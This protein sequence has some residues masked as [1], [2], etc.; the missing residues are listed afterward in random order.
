MAE[1]ALSKAEA[2]GVSAARVGDDVSVRLE[3][4]PTSG[5]RWELEHVDHQVLAPAGDEFIAEGAGR[6]AGGDRV[7]R[8]HVAKPGRTDVRLKRWRPWEGDTSVV[9]RFEATVEATD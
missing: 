3:E 9:E 1:V 7:F 5:Y 2:G 6:G 8:F 4:I